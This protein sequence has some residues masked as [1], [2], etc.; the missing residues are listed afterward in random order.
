MSSAPDGLPARP[1]PA[2]IDLTGKTIACIGDSITAGIAASPIHHA[3]FFGWVSQL[4]DQIS[5]QPGQSLNGGFRGL[6]RATEWLGAGTWANV[7]PED[8]F[9]VA[10]FGQGLWSQGDV[11]DVVRWAKPDDLVVTSFEL[12]W[13]QRPGAGRWQVRVDDGPW[14][15]GPE[16]TPGDGIQVHAVTAEVRERVEVRATTGTAPAGAFITGI[17]VYAAA[18]APERTT[19]H[20]LGFSGNWINV[21]ARGS[22]GD[23]LAVLDVL[24]P[25]F[26][27]IMFSNDVIFGAPAGFGKKMRS[28][29]DRVAERAEVLLICPF[30]QRPPRRVDDAR[31]RAGAT[32]LWSATARFA[33]SDDWR[34]V[35]GD[36]IVPETT[37]DGVISPDCIK[38]SKPAT[39][40][41]D[42][43]AFTI[44]AARAAGQQAAHRAVTREVA[45]ATGSGLLDLYDEW[46]TIAGPGWE[47]AD[48]AGLMIDTLHPS[49]RGHDDI[50]ARVGA[51]LATASRSR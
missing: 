7:T 42:A 25:D 39:T 36:A 34:A 43:G 20:N 16:P 32:A 14:T 22:A 40:T 35:L 19:V 31:T 33:P 12:H 5:E 38:L 10:P 11:L 4:A 13:S 23:P 44:G 49:Q 30:E 18:P 8:P 15:D 2:G 47:A 1:I 21:F 17:S 48:A 45:E 41:T 24:A 9:D 50:A 28:I 46:A 26:V 27:T 37:I 3:P 29:V 51:W 6:W